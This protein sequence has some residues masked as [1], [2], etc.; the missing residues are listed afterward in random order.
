MLKKAVLIGCSVLAVACGS[1][2]GVNLS[3]SGGAG[4]AGG[5]GGVAGVAGTGAA[6]GA[7]GQAGGGS[8]GSGNAAG[9][10]GAAGTGGA[11][12]SAGASSSLIVTEMMVN[13]KN[14]TDDLGEYV[15]LYNTTDAAIDLSGYE[16]YDG[17]NNT[18]VISKSVIVPAKGYALLARNG[19]PKQNGGLFPDYVYDNFFL[20]NTKDAVKL[21]DKS[22][23]VVA[24]VEYTGSAPWPA[25]DGAALELSDLSKDPADPASWT[26]AKNRYGTGD[27]G[28]PGGP[29]GYGPTP[30]TLDAADL[31][32]QDPSLGASLFF[33]YFDQPEKVIL[34]ALGKAQTSVHIAM[35]NLRES[36]II[37]ALGQLVKKGV[38]VQVLLDQKQMDQVYNQPK[39]QEL[40][41]A[42]ITPKGVSNTSAT[43]ATMHDKFT[44][45][46]GKRV[47]TGSMNYS[48][49]ALNLSDEELLLI[50]N[51]S[52]A[53][54]FEAE[55]AELSA[56]TTNAATA[57]T[58][59]PVQVLFGNED[60]L[61]DV[62]AGELAQAKT[63]AY[64]A[65]FS[66]NT[67]KIID[68]L[69]AAKSR[70]VHVVVLL[71]KVQAD[72]ES[73]DEALDQA[74]IPV[75]RFENDR[76][77]AQNLGLTELHNKLC[78]I[79]GKKVLM[80]SYNWT[81]LASFYNDENMLVLT[82]ER[83]AT[84]ANREIAQMIN[85]YMPA[86]TPQSV[87]FAAGK[88][89]VKFSLRG[90]S[91]DAGTELYLVGDSDAMG[92]DNY[93]LA[94]PLTA[95]AGN[96]WSTSVDLPAGAT[97]GYHVFARST[98]GHNYP[99]PIAA[100]TFT[101]PYASTAAVVDHAFGKSLKE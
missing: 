15:E 100:D 46:D 95:G 22:G 88:R 16:L 81:N 62:V 5:Y 55:F 21:K 2:D 1:D 10:S 32:W 26:L 63:S 37:N 13:P 67:K 73:A 14:V 38:D 12:G 50:D 91:V 54:L 94:L 98:L 77:S 86:F 65:M 20:S 43:D 27:L 9:S 74:G 3:G 47:L 34:Q 60:K 31:G 6:A 4:A 66:M 18:H 49:N 41:A 75:L 76:G 44:V 40:I 101:V 70:G 28:T 23:K 52:V 29:N 85:D 71:D 93:A 35:F 87:G 61:Y 30:Y 68:E 72:A 78:V 39:V 99:E 57:A 79:D 64:V 89:T 90:L 25:S 33:S 97:L 51:A 96:T 80:G 8:G 92:S 11:G 56:G 45:I 84:Q 82:S 69:I 83:L 58:S 19:D 24:S 17:F 36:S 42:G 59:A 53:S 7:A 48:S